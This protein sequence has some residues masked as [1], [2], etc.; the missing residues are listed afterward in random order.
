MS[1]SLS[2]GGSGVGN[3]LGLVDDVLSLSMSCMF[4]LFG[5]VLDMLK[6][7]DLMLDLLIGL[8]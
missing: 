5:L 1:G 6:L 3:G 7:L 4:L 2:S 8:G